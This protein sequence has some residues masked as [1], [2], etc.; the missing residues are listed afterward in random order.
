[1][2]IH[3]L[4]VAALFAFLGLDLPPQ[5]YIAKR[6]GTYGPSLVSVISVEVKMKKA[7]LR[8]NP[9]QNSLNRSKDSLTRADEGVRAMI[10]NATVAMGAQ[11][12]SP[13]PRG[14]GADHYL[15]LPPE[16]RW[17]Q[18]SDDDDDDDDDANNDAND[19]EPDSG[20]EEETTDA[21]I[22]SHYNIVREVQQYQKNYRKSSASLRA[23]IREQR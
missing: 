18:E 14:L 11:S 4:D 3:S 19:D 9:S 2:G 8:P 13:K 16:L 6:I 17:D 12:S 5:A 22:R 1:M 15:G 10:E 7:G 20:S 21:I 23:L